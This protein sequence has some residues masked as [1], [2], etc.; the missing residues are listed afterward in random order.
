MTPD[1]AL[2]VGVDK[3]AG[4]PVGL[5]VALDSFQFADLLEATVPVSEVVDDEDDRCGAQWSP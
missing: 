3:A 4:S 2:D 5:A 1:G